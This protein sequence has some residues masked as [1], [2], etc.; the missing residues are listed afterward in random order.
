MKRVDNFQIALKKFAD[1]E[2]HASLTT[3][4][5]PFSIYHGYFFITAH[6]I[7]SKWKVRES[8]L[9]FLRFQTP[10]KGTSMPYLRHRKIEKWSLW[11]KITSVIKENASDMT[12]IIFQLHAFLKN[13][14]PSGYSTLSLFYVR[15]FAHVGK[16]FHERWNE[17]YI[18]QYGWS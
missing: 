16:E 18:L 2:T 1:L 15:W 9:A 11:S 6:P 17:D 8:V 14:Y 13:S 10:H 7:D 3:D 5:W 12:N 4:A